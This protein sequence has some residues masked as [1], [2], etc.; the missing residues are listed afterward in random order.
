MLMRRLLAPFLL[1]VALTA[2]AAAQIQ[3]PIIGEFPECS[4]PSVPPGIV[5]AAS[6]L[7]QRDKKL[8]G[9]NLDG[10]GTRNRP[11]A[12]GKAG[13]LDGSLRLEPSDPLHEV[14]AAFRAS[15]RPKALVL[16]HT[17]PSE[18]DEVHAN[19]TAL[20][21]LQDKFRPDSGGPWAHPAS[22]AR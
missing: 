3:P 20:F 19:S 21:R 4:T 12:N 22:R 5:F 7:S 11:G 1:L 9:T 8:L 6:G 13:T 14:F 17:P 15:E 18:G 10:D 2:V 16:I